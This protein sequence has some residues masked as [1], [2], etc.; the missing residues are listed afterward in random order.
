MRIAQVAPLAE[1][2]PPEGY[3]GTERVVSYLTEELVRLG[4]DVTLFATADSETAADLEPM[5]PRAARSDPGL[6]PRPFETRMLAEAYRRSEEFDV[7]HCHTDYVGLPLSEHVATPTVVTLHGR[8]DVPGLRALFREFPD[9]SYVSISDSQRTAA[10]DIHWVATI[11]HGL[12]ERLY[13]FQPTPGDYLLFLGRVSPE[14]APDRA[15][16]IAVRAGVPL[17]IAAKVDAVD[18]E[19]F[20]QCVE[21][22]L[23]HPLVEFVGEVGGDQKLDLLAHARGL[24]FPIDWPEPFGLVM[25]E[26]LAC[27]TPVV[28]RQRGSVPEVLLHG[29]TGF[30]GETDDELSDA[31]SRLDELDR[32]R[33]REDFEQRF[34]DAEMT[35]KYLALYQRVSQ[36]QRRKS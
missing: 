13:A 15:I 25:I 3:G 6:D 30:I 9:V 23:G 29:E 24:L 20:A 4:H 1:S 17:K 31:I 16:R 32:R 33:C 36:A 22:L 12:P 34:T 18:Q 19:Y 2:V 7:I 5:S 21:P 14:K 27:G 10:P 26:A 28:A 35:R 8:L 11:H